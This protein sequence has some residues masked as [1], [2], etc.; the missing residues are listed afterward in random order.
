MSNTKTQT[1]TDSAKSQEQEQI[2]TLTPPAKAAYEVVYKLKQA[3]LR[4]Q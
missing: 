1:Q 3:K 4:K 2:A